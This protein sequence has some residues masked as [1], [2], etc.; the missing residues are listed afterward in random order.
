VD[1]TLTSVCEYSACRAARTARSMGRV[2]K[3]IGTAGVVELELAFFEI[4]VLALT[5]DVFASVGFASHCFSLSDLLV[6]WDDASYGLLYS[7]GGSL[8]GSPRLSTAGAQ[9][10]APLG[11]G[12]GDVVGCGVVF[13]TGAAAHLFAT[14]NGEFVGDSVFTLPRAAA[15]E[16]HPAISATGACSLR[17]RFDDFKFGEH[18]ALK[19]VGTLVAATAAARP[20]VANAA[21]ETAA[22]ALVNAADE[23]AGAAVPP[24]PLSPSSSAD[25]LYGA[26]RAPSSRQSRH[27]SLRADGSAV[28]TLRVA[29]AASPAAP[30]A[31]EARS[32]SSSDA[33]PKSMK[34]KKKPLPP[35]PPPSG[36]AP[37][38]PDAATR[39]DAPAEGA[40]AVG[41]SSP[42]QGTSRAEAEPLAIS[43]EAW[44]C[45]DVARWVEALD[46]AWKG[47]RKANAEAVGAEGAV[48]PD[49][50]SSSSS[51]SS[52][53]GGGGS[54]VWGEY[55]RRFR[56][57]GICGFQLLHDLQDDDLRNDLDMSVR[58]HRVRVL[59][60]RDELREAIGLAR[61]K[62]GSRC[63]SSLV[64]RSLSLF[65]PS[66][67]RSFSFSSSF[68]S[69]SRR[70]SIRRSSPP[71]A[72]QR[73]VAGTARRRPRRRPA[74][75]RGRP[76]SHLLR[77]R[78]Q[79]PRRHRRR[80][81]CLALR[82]WRS[83]R[84][85]RRRRLQMAAPLPLRRRAVQ[86]AR[87][88]AR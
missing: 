79:P 12:E 88:R 62:Q 56:A 5:E 73:H 6:G 49:S 48:A 43:E 68:P 81:D 36:G 30:A 7:E 45:S 59:R 54:S 26:P 60:S 77:Y 76:P 20:L 13:D 42:P 17:V 71:C 63:V 69:R 50:S 16:L 2:S 27:T 53:G 75:A 3:L 64:P 18:C 52:S 47:S 23:V 87:R 72:L 41:T 19:A 35:P 83:P 37:D 51:S 9:V 74:R 84:R 33:A 15:C 38:A 4:E 24:P 10:A 66:L 34:K 57:V 11:F 32:A 58:L 61:V 22:L 86:W 39:A 40:S 80:L 46:P 8:H 44:S 25:A 82:R 67:F 55:A 78:R 28:S 21:A 70:L 85:G 14:L 31:S 29:P 1:A 65:P